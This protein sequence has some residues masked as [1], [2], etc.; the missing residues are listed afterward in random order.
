MPCISKH[1]KVITASVNTA[2]AHNLVKY[3]LCKF[4]TSACTLRVSFSANNASQEIYCPK[5]KQCLVSLFKQ[6]YLTS[7]T[8][9][10]AL[11]GEGLIDT[12]LYDAF[13]ADYIK[14][15]AS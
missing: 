12:S 15:K 3:C 10:C 2:H 7:I 9:G 8:K 4:V 13:I 5:R 11:Q 14:N 1:Q 6:G